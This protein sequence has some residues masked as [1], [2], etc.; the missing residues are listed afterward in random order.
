MSLRSNG[1]EHA[2]G[3]APFTPS[4]QQLAAELASVTAQL[5]ELQRQ[6]EHA[7]R[8][9]SLGTLAATI[10]H[11]F[12]NILTPCMNWAQLALRSF[13]SGKPDL[14]LAQKAL[15]KCTAAGRKAGRICESILN[16]SRAP[17]QSPPLASECELNAVINEALTAMARDPAKDGITLRR[18]VPDG[19]KVAMDALQLEHVLV[20]LLIN[21]Q[22]SMHARRRG[23]ITINAALEPPSPRQFVK[24]EV[25]DTG[26]GI[27]PVDLPRIFDSFYTA[28]TP[29]PSRGTGLGLALCRTLLARSGGQISARSTPG[30]G[31]SFTLLLPVQAS[32]A[33]AAA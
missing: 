9:A 1:P 14:D 16:L 25:T 4:P 18:H 5:A 21:A 12:N 31:T 29:G 10:A 26:C 24:L 15:S 8:L 19:L 17:A 22:Q 7:D 33:R 6:L 32:S 2:A 3:S 20:N 13:E 27:D 30:R 23:M 11:E 28:R